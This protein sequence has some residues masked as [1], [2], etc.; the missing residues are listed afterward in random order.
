MCGIAGAVGHLDPEIREAVRRSD[1]AQVH[2]GPDAMGNWSSHS[3]DDGPGAVFFH[4]RLAIIDLSDGGRQPMLDPETG[5]VICFNGEIYNYRELRSELRHAGAIFRTETDTEV[6]LK[7]YAAWGPESLKRLRGM[8]AFALRVADERRTLLARDRLGIKPLYL[9]A[10]ERSAGRKALLFAS[11]VRALLEGGLIDRRLDPQ[12]LETYLWN[13]FVNGN[14]TIIANVS[15]LP[16]AHYLWVGD[17]GSLLEEGAFW[18]LPA[19]SERMGSTE[20]FVQTLEDSVAHRLISDVPLGVFLSGGIDSSAVAALASRSSASRIR[21]FNISFDEVEFDESAY[22]RAV[23]EGLGSEHEEI[24]LDQSHFKRHLES[25]LQS[26]DQPTFDAINTYFVSRAVREAGMTVALSGAGG[27]ELFGG[28]RSFRDIPRLAWVAER[29]S[30][31]PETLLRALAALLVRAKTGRLGAV[32]PQTRWGKLGDAL[33]SRGRLS[34]IYQISYGLFT[35]SFIE[36]LRKGS[37]SSDCAFGLSA[38]RMRELE[39]LIHGDSQLG[40]ISTLEL[41]NFVGQRLLRDTD[42][43]SMAVS[44]EVRVPLLDHHVVEAA[45]ALG[46][47]ARFQPLG[48][49]KLLREAALD[50]L[51]PRIFDRPKSGF[52]LPIERWSRDALRGEIERSFGDR[53]HCGESGLDC[54]AVNRLWKAY[55]EGAPGM[56]WSRIWALF[57]LLH[58]TRKHRVS[59]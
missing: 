41:K 27:D 30:A 51:D 21:T 36:E 39:E 2:R 3:D 14:R 17:D 16:E 50:R 29:T 42:T 20:E 43:A 4:R 57:V 46:D 48:S 53:S 9:T 55:Q 13:G 1:A 18:E 26:L 12:G 52:V 56:Y 44:L 37:P 34:E 11:E 54:D 31:F 10:I 7:A 38:E 40:A 15:C 33:A 22:A 47:E 58:W 28:Y 59:L 25:A 45:S 32:P 24:R 6:I 49:K 5:N 8:F 19:S 35:P 23:A